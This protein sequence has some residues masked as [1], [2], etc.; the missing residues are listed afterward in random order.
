MI[1]HLTS[2]RPSSTGF[3]S[4]LVLEDALKGW[5][6][7]ETRGRPHTV[8]GE[9]GWDSIQSPSS[10]GRPGDRQSMTSSTGVL[11]LEPTAGSVYC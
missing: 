6:T 8:G 9:G 3:P 5:L 7:L 11:P 10:I 1:N 2:V 4:C